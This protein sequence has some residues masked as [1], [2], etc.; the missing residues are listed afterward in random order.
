V[1]RIA[2]NDIELNVE[3]AGAGPPLVLLHGFTGSAASWTPHVDAF[4]GQYTVYAIDIV[5]HGRSDAPVDLAHY[6]MAQA[7]EDLRALLDRLDLGSITLL[8]YSM[9]GRVALHLALAYPTR[10]QALVLESASPGI[11]DSGERAARVRAD[12]SLAGSIERDG[13]AAFVD[14]W[15]RLPLFASQQRLPSDVWQQQRAVR[16][17]NRPIGLANSLRGMGAGAMEPVWD[18]LASFA[19]PVLLLA[20]ALDAKYVAQGE[21]ME[22]LLP[23]AKRL[24]LPDVGHTTHLEA[25]E[26]FARHVLDWLP[27]ATE[28]G[29]DA[30]SDLA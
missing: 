12:E 25:P 5:G 9:G 14:Y 22:R 2:V 8:G 23:R 27:S 17:A 18:R 15:E 7:V 3:R 28:G 24:V 29:D 10:I 20:G 26:L 6:R 1:S 13:L 4:A 21:T 16:L 11:A 30:R 19:P